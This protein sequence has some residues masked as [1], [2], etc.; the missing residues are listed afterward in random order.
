MCCSALWWLMGYFMVCGGACSVVVKLLDFDPQGQWLDPGSGRSKICAA[1]GPL[2]QTLNPTVLQAVCLLLRLSRF[3][4]KRRQYWSW[5][6][7]VSG[8][9]DAFFFFLA[10]CYY[11]SELHSTLSTQRGSNGPQ[12]AAR[13]AFSGYVAAVFEQIHWLIRKHPALTVPL[14]LCPGCPDVDTGWDW[15]RFHKLSCGTAV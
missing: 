7:S 2:S 12:L 8:V 3:R 13:A 5:G 10:F 6:P 14:P 15:T 4:E 1:V 9:L 11:R